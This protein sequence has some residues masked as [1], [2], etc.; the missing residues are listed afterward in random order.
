LKTLQPEKIVEVHRK[1]K[2]DDSEQTE[3]LSKK[4]KLAVYPGEYNGLKKRGSTTETQNPAEIV[5]YVSS[6]DEVN[7]RMDCLEAGSQKRRVDEANTDRPP[8]KRLKL[9]SS[10][11]NNEEDMKE[12]QRS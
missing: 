6:G 12:V 8:A 4:L 3:P 1:R 10:T 9:L 11:C 2:N 7:A 5:A